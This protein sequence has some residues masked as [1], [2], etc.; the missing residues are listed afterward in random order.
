MDY[1]FAYKEALNRA[2]RFLSTRGISPNENP[3]SVALELAE[4]TFPELNISK[5][6]TIK[7]TIKNLIEKSDIQNIYGIKKEDCL[8][9]LENIN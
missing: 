4:T 6:E 2:K 1:E 8:E 5:E 3:F 7:R 9:W